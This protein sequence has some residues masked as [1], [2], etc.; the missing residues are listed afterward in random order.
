MKH[1]E[2]PI[3][4]SVLPTGEWN[5]GTVFQNRFTI[6]KSIDIGVASA[7]NPI[8]NNPLLYRPHHQ[9]IAVAKFRAGQRR[10]KCPESITDKMFYRNET[11]GVC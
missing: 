7:A 4:H 8:A 11:K 3:V 9:A 5:G 1:G 6:V 2:D 10:C